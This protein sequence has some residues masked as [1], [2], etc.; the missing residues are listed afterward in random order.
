MK[1]NQYTYNWFKL[2]ILVFAGIIISY[3][4]AFSKTIDLY[5]QKNNDDAILLEIKSL[6]ESIKNLEKTIEK[7]EKN[8]FKNSGLDSLSSRQKILDLFAI[9]SAK[10][11]FS[12]KEVSPCF[13]SSLDSVNYELSV[14]TLEGSYFELLK[15]WNFIENEIHF[16]NIPS[17]RFF[18]SED[19]RLNTKKLN[20]ILYVEL[21]K[22]KNRQ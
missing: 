13:L 20:L 12:V 22:N 21:F 18:I 7:N 3:L 17:S 1:K 5:K 2:A 4:L 14:F 8:Q 15:T 19:F 11:S 9:A 10:Y 6:P 16:G